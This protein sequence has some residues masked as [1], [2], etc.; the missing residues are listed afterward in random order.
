MEKQFVPHLKIKL[1]H[2][3]YSRNNFE[4]L[5]SFLKH[6]VQPKKAEGYGQGAGFYL[7]TTKELAIAHATFQKERHLDFS[8]FSIILTFNEKLNEDEWDLDYE[9]NSNLIVAFLRGHW[10]LFK[11]IPDTAI[12]RNNAYLTVSKCEKNNFIFAKNITL[13]FSDGH[14]FSTID[15]KRKDS[16]IDEASVLGKIF[17]YLQ[18]N[19]PHLTKHFEKSAFK[20]MAKRGTAIKYVGS[21]PL[22]ID[23]FNIE[24]NSKWL[25][26]KKSKE[27][28]ELSRN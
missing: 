20:V 21:K 19:H 2:T 26:Y 13:H 7:W 18:E 15:A 28:F 1:Y 24:I 16:D 23:S 5:L 27:F 25:N 17:N 9:V 3:T 4:T 10:K 11:T 12:K 6:G 8:G 22:K 14:S